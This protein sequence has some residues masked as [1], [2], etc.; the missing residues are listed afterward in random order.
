MD[1][2]AVA[3]TSLCMF[4]AA[5]SAGAGEVGRGPQPSAR[6]IAWE[7]QFEYLEPRRIAVGGQ[8]YWYMVYTVT[9]YSGAT[10]RFFPTCQLVTQDLKVVDTDVGISTA[11][12]E[13]I[14]A[15]HIKTHKYLVPPA[16]AIGDL[17]VGEGYARES[18]AIWRGVDVPGNRFCVFV[19]GIS[20]ESRLDPNPGFDAAQPESAAN[21]RWFTLRKT[22]ELQYR[23]PGSDTARQS[24]LPVLEH[25][26]WIMR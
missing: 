15:R 20:G 10:Q 12:F 1:P 2:L 11:V 3:T 17:L 19:A 21:P 25:A 6:P 16:Q 18:V 9:N 14:R 4:L 8:S 13:A 7:L 23:L 24:A 5:Q 22:L 26:R